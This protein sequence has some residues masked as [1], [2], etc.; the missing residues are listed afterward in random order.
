MFTYVYIVCRDQH[1]LSLLRLDEAIY[2]YPFEGK[3]VIS[4]NKRELITSVIF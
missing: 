1:F 2:N 3:I 4:S